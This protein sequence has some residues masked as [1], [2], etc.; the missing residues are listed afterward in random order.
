MSELNLIA[1]KRATEEEQKKMLE[2]AKRKLHDKKLELEKINSKLERGFADDAKLNELSPLIEMKNRFDMDFEK[3]NI[4]FYECQRYFDEAQSSEFTSNLDPAPS[5]SATVDIR[6]EIMSKEKLER[7]R[8]K[9][10]V[11]TLD[12][13]IKD[14][15]LRRPKQQ[16]QDPKK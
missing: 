9:D 5:S 14:N 16:N 1:F 13:I 4:L 8:K 6:P 11:R 10:N 2:A 12:Q 15:D 7:L 3:L